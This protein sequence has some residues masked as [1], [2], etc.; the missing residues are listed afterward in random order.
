[1]IINILQTILVLIIF[2]PIKW[3][4]YKITEEWGLPEWLQYK[5]YVC[6]K[7]LSFWSLMALFLSSGLLCHLWITMA[8]GLILTILDTVAVIVDQRNK[9]IKIYKDGDNE[10]IT[11]N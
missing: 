2:F 10:I 6:R 3:L 8:V 4:C 9:T 11:I 7:C 5:P 1:M